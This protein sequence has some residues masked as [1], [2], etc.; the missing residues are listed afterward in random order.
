MA[1]QPEYKQRI[2]L[3]QPE[4]A[5]DHAKGNPDAAEAFCG[6]IQNTGGNSLPPLLPASFRSEFSQPV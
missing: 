3:L 1:E 6:K 5:A 2:H 4:R